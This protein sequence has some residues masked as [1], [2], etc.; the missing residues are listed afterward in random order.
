MSLVTVLK[1]RIYLPYVDNLKE[2]RKVRFSLLSRIKAQNISAIE[3]EDQDL[4]N[5]LVLLLSFTSLDR[6]AA[7][8]KKK[9]LEDLFFENSQHVTIE[10]EEFVF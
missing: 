2:K 7:L 9:K 5:Y 6:G 4:R 1:V 10:G 3:V 8:T